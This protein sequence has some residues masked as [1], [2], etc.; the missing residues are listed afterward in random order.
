MLALALCLAISACI[1]TKAP[2]QSGLAAQSTNVIANN[3]LVSTQVD[4]LTGMWIGALEWRADQIRAATSDPAIRFNAL[5]WKI[6]G[7]SAV[8]QATSH[9]DPL[10]A[11][12]DAWTL[13]FQATEYFDT[14]PGA[15]AL[16]EH[17]ELAR[18]LNELAEAEFD[19][20]VASIATPEGVAN[21][22]ALAQAFAADNPV[23]N[24]YFLRASVA[25]TIVATLSEDQRD[26]FANLGSIT[27]TVETLGAR[28][29]I[30]L[31]YLPRLARWQAELLL[32]DPAN[33]AML[34]DVFDNLH[35]V[36]ATAARVADTLDRTVDDKLDEV[37]ATALG[38][39]ATE[40]DD[41][42]ALVNA[43]RQ[44]IL[45]EL[46]NE[47]ERIFAKVTEQ[48]LAALSQVEAK[49]DEALDRVDAVADRSLG[50]AEGLTRGTVDYAF[51][52]ATPLLIAA[53]FGLLILILVYRLVPQRVRRD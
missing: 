11:V 49:I 35:E 28:L 29:S 23:L 36:N 3:R 50:S 43:Q 33:A 4:E 52:R 47:Y 7:T 15:A 38:Q 42:E 13:L 2:A 46:P 44:L 9:G 1:S 17:V 24:D 41:V 22:R 53:F 5:L 14:G 19:Q 34:T 40:L 18:E 10:I 12:V 25:G 37:L 31:D 26:A 6:N 30:Y 39:L 8:L 51:E 21:G 45:S 32:E 16:G 27:Q 20:L 48:R